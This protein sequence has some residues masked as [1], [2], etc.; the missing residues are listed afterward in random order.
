MLCYVE[1]KVGSMA[2]MNKQVM[3]AEMLKEVTY[4]DIVDIINDTGV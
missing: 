4:T 2:T 1:Q 3:T